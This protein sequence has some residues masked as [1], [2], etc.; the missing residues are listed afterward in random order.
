MM[1][2]YLLL[3]FRP[4]LIH[5]IESKIFIRNQCSGSHTRQKVACEDKEQ[6]CCRCSNVKRVKYSYSELLVC[7]PC[8][9]VCAPCNLVGGHQCCGRN[10]CLPHQN[11]TDIY[12][13]NT[14]SRDSSKLWCCCPL[15]KATQHHIPQERTV[16]ITVD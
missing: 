7:A 4:T 5:M 15:Y 12:S 11:R 3:C 2:L 10:C 16:V 14:Q 1:Q 9:L 6:E 13:L 8:N